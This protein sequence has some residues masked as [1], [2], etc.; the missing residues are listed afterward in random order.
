MS[1][2]KERMI[3]TE[4][5]LE[6]R[7]QASGRFLDVR[8][9][10]ADHFKSNELFPHWQ[11]DTNVVQFR[12]AP[13][14]PKKIGA[15]AGYKSAGLYTFDPETRNYF[16]DK[17]G[18]FWKTLSKNQFY[19]IP[20]IERFGCRTK[21]FLNCSE[22]FEDINDKLYQKFFSD[23]FRG[24]IG[25]KEKDLQ[26]VI[27]LNAGKFEIKINCGPI[28]KDEAN[29]YF[30]FKS[31]HFDDTGIFLDIDVSIVNNIQSS[32]ISSLVKEAMSLTWQKIDNISKS[33]GI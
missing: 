32:K 26:I 6:I 9:Y 25:E 31:D 20:E 29:N 19:T 27:N 22:A 14:S 4:H 12:D 13:K 11:I 18:Q 30:N 24:L 15:F 16:E 17:A 2:N 8:G 5:I 7:H 21:A 1:K 3:V 23:E 33:V 10:V 28:K